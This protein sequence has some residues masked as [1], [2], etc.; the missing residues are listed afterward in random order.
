MYGHSIGQTPKDLTRQV[1]SRRGIGS[2][3]EGGARNGTGVLPRRLPPD[4][5]RPA[6]WGDPS[7]A[8]DRA[9]HPDQAGRGLRRNPSH[10]LRERDGSRC[11]PRGRNHLPVALR[12]HPLD[13]GH[14]RRA[15]GPPPAP[16]G[17]P[18]ARGPRPH[19]WPRAGHVRPVRGPPAE[20]GEGHGHRDQ[21]RH[22]GVR[23]AVPPGR[24]AVG[25][26]AKGY[27]GNWGED[28]LKMRREQERRQERRSG[29][30][31]W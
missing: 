30:W 10:D 21:P 8:T 31:G 18:E 29:G 27:R 9:R 4:A 7:E 13:V 3:S 16:V 1:S 14:P 6:R 26:G 23:A 22:R 11:C 25:R 12:R 17:R 5:H 19:R 24:P 20:R 15:T 2:R 28:L